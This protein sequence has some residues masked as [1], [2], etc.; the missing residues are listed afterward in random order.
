MLILE[1]ISDSYVLIDTDFNIDTELSKFSFL[2]YDW[3]APNPGKCYLYFF[4][5]TYNINQSINFQLSAPLLK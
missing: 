1:K 5:K 4:L 3:I 2:P